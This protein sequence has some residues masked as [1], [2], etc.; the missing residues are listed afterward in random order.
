MTGLEDALVEEIRPSLNGKP[1]KP[2]VSQSER[3]EVENEKD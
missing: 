3:L 2:L 1:A